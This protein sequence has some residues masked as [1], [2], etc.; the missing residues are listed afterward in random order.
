[1]IFFLVFLQLLSDVFHI[2]ASYVRLSPPF[3]DILI[4]IPFLCGEAVTRCC[5]AHDQP[6]L[7]DCKHT[8]LRSLSFEFS[9]EFRD[10]LLCLVQILVQ[11]SEQLLI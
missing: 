9:L 10:R 5:L 11:I 2:L 8:K 4:H 7:L 3:H 6:C 1:M